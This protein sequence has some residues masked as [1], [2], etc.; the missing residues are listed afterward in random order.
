MKERSGQGR[1]R[2]AASQ[3]VIK[4]RQ[5]AR[6]PGG[7][8]RNGN[9]RSHG[10]QHGDIEASLGA[11]GVHRGEQNFAGP[12]GLDFP[13]PRHQVQAGGNAAAVDNHFPVRLAGRRLQR[14]RQAGVNCHHDALAAKAPR[15]LRNQPRLAH[16]RRVDGGLVC[17]GQEHGAHVVHAAQA[18]AHG[19]RDEDRVGHGAH[20]LARDGAAFVRGGDV[21]ENQLIGAFG[22][23]RLRLRHRVARVAQIEEIDAFDHAAIFDIEARNDAFG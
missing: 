8:H 15:A 14:R 5:A 17:A 18:A 4:M 1:L 3:G 20:D 23:V 22:I 2:A 13:G 12:T 11:V 21:Q 9:G 10:L 19:E 6:A 7:N 16:G